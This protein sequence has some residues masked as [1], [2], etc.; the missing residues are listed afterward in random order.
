MFG[1][2]L[3]LVGRAHGWVAGRAGLWGVLPTRVWVGGTSPQ[4]PE[5][6]TSI[7]DAGINEDKIISYCSDNT[8]FAIVI[9]T[10]FVFLFELD[11]KVQLSSVKVSLLGQ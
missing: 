4:V 11:A 3:G 9:L 7:C 2:A 6:P 5:H 10:Y 8:A 1:L